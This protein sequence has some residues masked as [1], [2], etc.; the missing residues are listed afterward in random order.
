MNNWEL[1]NPEPRSVSV[2]VYG[3][4]VDS[5]ANVYL[6]DAKYDPDLIVWKEGRCEGG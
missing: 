6:A 4:G 5:E 3:I 1:E 2:I